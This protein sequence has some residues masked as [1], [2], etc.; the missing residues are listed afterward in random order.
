LP[1]IDAEEAWQE[2]LSAQL[3]FKSGRICANETGPSSAAGPQPLLSAN[4][5]ATAASVLAPSSPRRLL[6]SE[7]VIAALLILGRAAV[8]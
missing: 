7:R 2:L 6:W 8:T 1:E 4:D 3:G 5:I